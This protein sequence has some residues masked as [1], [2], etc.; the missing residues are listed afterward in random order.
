[1]AT[2]LYAFLL[3][4]RV[5]HGLAVSAFG[6]A[7]SIFFRYFAAHCSPPRS[8]FFLELAINVFL[9]ALWIMIVLTAIDLLARG[10]RAV[11]HER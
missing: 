10:C 4:T 11:L 3:Y 9:Y 7:D 5:L 2:A 1:M 8:C 6:P